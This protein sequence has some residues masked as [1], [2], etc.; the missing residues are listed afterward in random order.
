MKLYIKK[1]WSWNPTKYKYMGLNEAKKAY[2]DY[3]DHC[4][5]NHPKEPLKSFEDWRTTEI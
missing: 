5:K 3:F 2:Q 4:N 1:V